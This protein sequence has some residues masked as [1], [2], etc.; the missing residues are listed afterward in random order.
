MNALEVYFVGLEQ[1][2][3]EVVNDLNLKNRASYIYRTGVPLPSKCCILSIFSTNISAEKFKY[4][5]HSQ[6]FFSKYRL[7]H[8][9]TFFGSCIIHILHTVCAKI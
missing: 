1:E 3:D 2:I 7:F 8:N 4:A 5:E 9:T 6:F